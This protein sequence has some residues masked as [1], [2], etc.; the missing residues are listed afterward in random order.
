MRSALPLVAL[1]LLGWLGPA[2]GDAQASRSGS[3]GDGIVRGGSVDQFRLGGGE[4]TAVT[5]RI[6]SLRRGTAG[7]DVALSLFPTA[8]AYRTLILAPTAGAAF[9]IDLGAARLLLKAGASGIVGLGG[10]ALLVPGVY[11][12]VGGLV[13]ADRRLALRFDLLRHFYRIG[14]ETQPAWSAGLGL[15]VLPR[16]AP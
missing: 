12:G 1:T 6:T 15:A 16:A 7:T 10:G 2:T 5:F 14:G 13:K 8:L 4:A 3:L 9:S 11:A